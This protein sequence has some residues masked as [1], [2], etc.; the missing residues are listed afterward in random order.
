M[1]HILI[2]LR[3]HAIHIPGCSFVALHLRLVR[4]LC[5]LSFCVPAFGYGYA[6]LC[7]LVSI[8]MSTLV[9]KHRI[10]HFMEAQIGR[11]CC[12]KYVYL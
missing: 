2:I 9:K 5:I 8:V 12:K 7:N 4:K 6:A 10:C 11:S 1:T 3:I